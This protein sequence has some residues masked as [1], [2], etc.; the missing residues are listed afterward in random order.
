MC[1]IET[2]DLVRIDG[3]DIEMLVIGRA[4][5]DLWN[6]GSRPSVFCVW[7]QHDILFEE[8]MAVE[9][10]VLVRRERRRIPRGGKLVFPCRSV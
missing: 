9:R 2:G 1:D 3:A 5:H 7:E 6:T 10:L 4:D 8:V